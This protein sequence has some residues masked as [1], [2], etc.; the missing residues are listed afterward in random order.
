MQLSFTAR[1]TSYG[2]EVTRR[3]PDGSEEVMIINST[4]RGFTRWLKGWRIYK[5]MPQLTL[6]ERDFLILGPRR[7]HRRYTGYDE[8][9]NAAKST[10]MISDE[11]IE[12]LRINTALDHLE[13]W[14]TWGD[15]CH[16][17]LMVTILEIG[18]IIADRGTPLQYERI[19]ALWEAVTI[20]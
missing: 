17:E 10:N 4:F 3:D 8:L 18:K 14:V 2:L 12:G 7:D 11:L 19:D 15:P 5:A 6:A 1:T 9:M 20:A 16:E 13:E